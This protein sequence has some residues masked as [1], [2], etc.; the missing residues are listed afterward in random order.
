MSILHL[1]TTDKFLKDFKCFDD[2]HRN[3]TIL[4]TFTPIMMAGMMEDRSNG[5]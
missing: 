3:K 5:A 1:Y 2:K 4:L